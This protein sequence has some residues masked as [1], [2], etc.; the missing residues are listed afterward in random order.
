M[1]NRVQRKTPLILPSFTS[2]PQVAL[3]NPF[4]V[5]LHLHAWNGF[6]NCK[7][8]YFLFTFIS[9]DVSGWKKEKVFN[10]RGRKRIHSPF[11]ALKDGKLSRLIHSTSMSSEMEKKLPRSDSG[12][13]YA[14]SQGCFLSREAISL[15]E[16]QLMKRC[17]CWKT[18]NE[19][20][21]VGLGAGGV[22]K[23]FL[24]YYSSITRIHCFSLDRKS[25]RGEK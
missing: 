21:G 22:I 19:K 10:F 24:N 23:N 6:E 25:E 17:H 16:N 2:N 11:A 12:K 4:D 7:L 14:N 5:V 20:G 9:F 18:Q 3:I 15:I 1:F 13:V 8:L